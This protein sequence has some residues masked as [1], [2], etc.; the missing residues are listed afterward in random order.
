MKTLAVRIY[1]WSLWWSRS[2]CEEC[3]HNLLASSCPM[4]FSIL[5]VLDAYTQSSANSA[6]AKS[7]YV[8][9]PV[10]MTRYSYPVGYFTS[11]I[12]YT[13][14]LVYYVVYSVCTQVGVP[15]PRMNVKCNAYPWGVQVLTSTPLLSGMKWLIGLQW[16]KII[17]SCPWNNKAK[18]SSMI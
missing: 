9:L 16:R 5:S 8:I 13:C 17:L 14:Y 6:H 15:S 10:T 12:N 4:I 18:I 3:R 7:T 11:H 1:W 2:N